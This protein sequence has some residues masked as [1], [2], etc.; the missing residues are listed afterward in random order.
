MGSGWPLRTVLSVLFALLVAS[1]TLVTLKDYGIVWD[2]PI[3][4][5]NGD[6]SWEW[7]LKPKPEKIPEVFGLQAEI[8]FHP[9][10][11]KWLA[12]AT[13]YIATNRLKLIDNTRGYRISGLLFVVPLAFGYFFLSTAL[14]GYTAGALSA[15]LVLFHPAIFAMSHL[16]TLDYAVIA[17]YFGIG[18]LLLSGFR[19]T[20][21][22]G[23]AGFLAGI[24]LDVKIHGLLFLGVAGFIWMADIFRTGFSNR[25]FK[26]GVLFVLVA[27]SVAYI[28]WPLLWF[29][30]ISRYRQYLGMQFG[31]PGAQSLFFGYVGSFPPWWYVPF[32]IS[33]ITP[34]FFLAL[35][36]CGGVFAWRGRSEERRILVFAL[37]P[38]LFFSLP[39]VQNYDNGRLLLPSVPFFGLLAALA[40][41]KILGMARRI[42]ID[43]AVSVILALLTAGTL[44]GSTVSYH[45]YE[46]SYFN[47]LV[48]GIRGAERLHIDT[49]YWGEAYKDILPYMNAHKGT[50]FCV[51]PV[52]SPFY[53]YQAMGQLE[54][55]V[56][57]ESGD[58]CTDMVVLRREG[59]IQNNPDV[60]Q[61]VRSRDPEY[62]VL[63]KGVPMVSV[64]R[65]LTP[66][67]R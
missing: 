31:H 56:I 3:Y 45:P 47:E 43:G 57:F 20:L 59:F 42:R 26:S 35:A 38:L 19:R 63:F 49:T 67:M 9:P 14:F 16:V 11:R 12:G 32:M 17:L 44:Y 8:D 2:E 28:G 58:A 23:I 64:F 1:V 60:G 54:P 53:Y 18:A 29:D 25:I 46:L 30:P 22:A 21:R 13:R 5:R 48:G 7:F 36:V 34:V 39:F 51:F 40:M 15:L 4:F 55:G 66:Q 37:L 62:S 33:A 61:L 52:T 65:L 6:A 27:F 24:S 10:L 50:M 41:Q